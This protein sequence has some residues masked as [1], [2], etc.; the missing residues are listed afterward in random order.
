MKPDCPFY[1]SF[2]DYNPEIEGCCKKKSKLVI[3]YN[4]THEPCSLRPKKSQNKSE[5]KLIVKKN[6]T[7]LDSLF[8]KK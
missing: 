5:K 1:I 2:S 3:A 4:C 6:P 7:I 8:R